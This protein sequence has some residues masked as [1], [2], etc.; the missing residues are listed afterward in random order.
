MPAAFKTVAVVGKSDAPSLPDI[1]EQL[2]A[3][4]R[5]RGIG[6]V[7]DPLTAGA[8]RTRPDA[9][10]EMASLPAKADLAVVV[11]GDG[12]L[13]AAARLMAE[14]GV[15]LVGVNLGRL[16]FLTDIP[17]DSVAAAIEA[18]LEGD[19]VPEQRLLLSGSVRRAGKTMIS[20]TAMNDVVVS[21]GA[22]GSMIEFAVT[23][24]GEFIYS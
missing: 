12:T 21:R 2:A 11:G 5:A 10:V 20:A 4:L 14:H 1:L 19:F 13:I 24:D 16:G 6:M 18:V 7:M 22:L 23:V 15:P 17:A 8:A 9:I 3:V